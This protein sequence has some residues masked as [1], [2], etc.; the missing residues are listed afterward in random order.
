MPVRAQ[1]GHGML[2]VACERQWQHLREPRFEEL[3]ID[4]CSG[5]ADEVNV[6]WQRNDCWQCTQQALPEGERRNT[7]VGVLDVLVLR[8]LGTLGAGR[9]AT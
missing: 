6:E 2:C 3:R 7:T 4:A 1:E 9:M 8:L 5:G